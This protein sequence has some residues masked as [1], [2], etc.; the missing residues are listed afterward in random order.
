M[1]PKH[2]TANPMSKV[3]NKNSG[4]TYRD[5]EGVGPVVRQPDA[6][7]V[8]VALGAELLRDDLRELPRR[9]GG[10]LHVRELEDGLDHLQDD[11]RR[12]A[13][14]MSAPAERE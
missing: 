7:D 11:L 6:V 3:T 13:R 12:E 2:R 8:H 10:A 9:A 14:R 1:T 5:Q 4:S